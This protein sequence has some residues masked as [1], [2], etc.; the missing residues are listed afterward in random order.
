MTSRDLAPPPTHRSTAAAAP[1]HEHGW[2]TES[3]HVTS[4]GEIRY[5]RCPECGVRRMDLLT[6]GGLVAQGASRI[7]GERPAAG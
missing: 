7:V 6:P 1:G 2:V 3:T 4:H 5:V